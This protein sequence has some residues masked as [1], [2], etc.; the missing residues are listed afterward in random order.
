M[1][2][3]K[4]TMTA[5]RVTQ[6]TPNHLLITLP[7]AS[8][9]PLW[10]LLLLLAILLFTTYG[11]SRTVKRVLQSQKTPAELRAYISRYRMVGT[12]ISFG[13]IGLFWLISYSS[14]SI[15][16]DRSANRVTMRSKMTAFLPA[17]TLSIPLAEVDHAIVDY[18]PNSARIRLVTHNNGG[19]GYPMWSGRRGQEEAVDAI[20]HFL[21]PTAGKN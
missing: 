16:L 20:N 8:L 18:K 11:T 9:A 12:A 1:G 14:G 3:T 2:V 19:L 15:D 21:H 4:G 10:F 5:Y 7:G 17:Q 13:C 6:A